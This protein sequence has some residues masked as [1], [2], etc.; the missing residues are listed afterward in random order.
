M[1][2]LLAYVGPLQLPEGTRYLTPE[3]RH[4]IKAAT[5]CTAVVRCRNQWGVPALSLSGPSLEFQPNFQEIQAL[6][7]NV[8]EARCFQ[9]AG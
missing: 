1:A 4:E 3:Q 8:L 6:M 2:G 7:A 9:P 5:D